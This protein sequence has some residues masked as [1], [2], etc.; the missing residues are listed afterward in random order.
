M[1]D[2]DATLSSTYMPPEPEQADTPAEAA[3][4]ACPDVAAWERLMM[5]VPEDWLYTRPP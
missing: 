4:H 2:G 5:L 3:T 1:R